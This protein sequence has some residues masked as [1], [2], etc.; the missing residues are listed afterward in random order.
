MSSA[1]FD[2]AIPLIK[3]F[4]GLHDGDLSMIGLQPKPCPAGIWTAGWGHA[5]KT[6]DEKRFLK[7]SKDKAEAYRQ[8][9]C[10]TLEQADDLLLKDASAALKSL[11]DA[12]PVMMYQSPARQAAL[13][14]WVFN[15]GIGNYRASTLKKRVDATDWKGAKTE[16]VRWNKS[17]GKVLPGLDRRRKAEAKL[18]G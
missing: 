6:H 11:L 13:L 16:S 4:E 5:L 14:S 10:M 3:E 17:N 7:G 9:A 18:L 15:L 1:V 8:C 2:I 12:S